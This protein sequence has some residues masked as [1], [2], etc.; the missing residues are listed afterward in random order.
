MPDILTRRQLCRLALIVMLMCSMVWTVPAQAYALPS[1]TGGYSNASEQTEQKKIKMSILMIGNSQTYS[2]KQRNR[3]LSYLKQLGAAGGYSFTIAHVAYDN[4]KLKNYAN[5]SGRRG[6]TARKKIR[7]R[8]WNVIIL[9]E[10]TDWA[11]ARKGTFL[12]AAKTL[13]S[14]IRKNCSGAKIYLDCTW[15]Y[16]KVRRI[17]GKSYSKKEQ[18]KRMNANYKSVGKT[19]GATVIYSGKTFAAYEKL[20]NIKRLYQGD[21][22]HATYAGCYLHACCLYKG[23]TKQNPHGLNYYGPLIR[24][25][26]RTMQRVANE[27]ALK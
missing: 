10:N 5:A 18:Q 2:V 22:N 9:Q 24:G 19:I 4:E 17:S 14:Y 6:Q 20:D 25:K 1:L 8:K 12:K 16:N 15:A 3:T 11:V 7:S 23:I 27:N 21:R 13:A 26:A